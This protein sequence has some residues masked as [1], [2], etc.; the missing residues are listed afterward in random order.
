M[1]SEHHPEQPDCAAC[2][3]PA[4]DTTDISHEQ[5][6]DHDIEATAARPGRAGSA[7]G[8]AE[9]LVVVG[10]VR[11]S[12]AEYGMAYAQLATRGGAFYRQEALR[13][14]VRAAEAGPLEPAM[15]AELGY[16]LQVS[17]QA[18]GARAAYAAALRQDPYQPTA[19]GNLGVLE[20]ATGQ[21]AEAVRLLERLVEAD[22]SQTAAGLNLAWIECRVGQRTE[23]RRVLE[24]LQRINPDNPQL[25]AFE[26]SGDYLGQHCALADV[27]AR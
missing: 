17:G 10:G 18:E 22:P 4:R 26:G 3:M 21:V 19:L 20:A 16:L 5:V 13:R 15:A 9:E 14:L 7:R 6:T 12:E 2:H 27:A 1:A 25:R 24:R 11:A 8:G 23:A